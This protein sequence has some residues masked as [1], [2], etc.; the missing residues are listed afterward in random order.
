MQPIAFTVV[1][2]INNVFDQ[3]QFINVLCETE[4]VIIH[5]GCLQMRIVGL[6]ESWLPSE[7]SFVFR[8]QSVTASP[9]S[10]RHSMRV[11]QAKLCML[12]V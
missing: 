2:L 12:Q 6:P 11:L 3:N 4:T 9:K 7:F 5:G 10:D 8:N 1:L